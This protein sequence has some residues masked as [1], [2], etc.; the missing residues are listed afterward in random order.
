MSARVTARNAYL[1]ATAS[2]FLLAGAGLPARAAVQAPPGP[3]DGPGLKTIPEV[4][5][6]APAAR[7]GAGGDALSTAGLRQYAMTNRQLGAVRGGFTFANGVTVNFGFR[8]VGTINGTLVEGLLVQPDGQA[9]NYQTNIGAS[10]CV[11]GCSSSVSVGSN[12][13]VVNGVVISGSGG[14]ASLTVPS[15]WQPTNTLSATG[16]AN[17]NP[18]GTPT[19]T[20]STSIGLNGIVNSITNTANQQLLNQASAIDIT[21]TGLAAAIAAEQAVNSVMNSITKAVRVP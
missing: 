15:G 9:Y 14:N 4:T 12:A 7:A 13:I 2:L 3:F 1:G 17:N 5:V 11:S 6:E 21:V 19:T 10:S 8:E 20:I 16:G 18:N